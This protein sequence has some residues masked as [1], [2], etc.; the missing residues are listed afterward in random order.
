MLI[1]SVFILF[2]SSIDVVL[3][4]GA[5]CNVQGRCT[6]NLTSGEC[7]GGTHFE[8][9]PCSAIPCEPTGACCSAQFQCSEFRTKAQCGSGVWHQDRV[10]NF[11][12]GPYGACCNTQGQCNHGLGE[13]ECGSTS[14]WTINKKCNDVVC[15]PSKYFWFFDLYIENVI[16]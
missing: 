11:S 15:G 10:C 12:C 1:L 16:F 7:G 4:L 13:N 6:N 9:Q 14:T 3:S 2:I 8:G 5:C